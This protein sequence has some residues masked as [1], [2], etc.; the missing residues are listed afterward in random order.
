MQSLTAREPVNLT[1]KEASPMETSE[2][3]PVLSMSLSSRD[4]LLSEGFIK[5]FGSDV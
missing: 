5:I 3:T 2:I 1:G 4:E